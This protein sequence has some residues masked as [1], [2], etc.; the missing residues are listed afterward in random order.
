[1]TDFY[2]DPTLGLSANAGTKLAPKQYISEVTMAA[3][4]RIFL[5][6]GRTHPIS[7]YRFFLSGQSLDAYGEGPLP[8]LQKTA[9]PDA[10][11]Y[12]RN[13]DGVT[14]KNVDLD[15]NGYNGPLLAVANTA[16]SQAVTNFLL[17]NLS[18]SG[19]PN[20]VGLIIAGS[21]GSTVR[22][23]TVRNCTFADNYSHGTICSTDV[24]GVRYEGCISRR[25][26]FGVG[27][28]GFS[29]WAPS[30]S[31][32][33]S[34]IVWFG[35]I[36]EDIVDFDGIEGQGF[37]G[38]DNSS[39]ISAIG[40]IARHCGGYGF[41]FNS[42]SNGLVTGC[43]AHD[44]DGPGFG[45]TGT[46]TGSR[47]YNNTSVGNALSASVSTEISIGGSSVNASIKN[48]IFHGMSR[49]TNGIYVVGGASGTVATHNCAYGVT[50]EASGVTP[51]SS[52]TTDPLL[53]VSYRIP[54][55]S[56]CYEAG[57]YIAGVRDFS[58]RK[59]RRTPDIGAR[60]FLATRSAV[61]PVRS[62]KAVARSAESTPRSSRIINT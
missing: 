57:T 17:D 44:N 53:D 60:Q 42:S 34:N 24:Q 3:N 47:F 35:C 32:A 9:G 39:Y 27:A 46:N 55:T 52:V 49:T 43:I 22:R 26:G 40:C 19:S 25:N 48:N 37:Q 1:M 50:T 4:N 10:W 18:L 6:R 13:A 62:A 16:G 20:S 11:I 51:S 8:I 33:P 41:L 31:P 5:R 23:G 30:A 54:L 14:I 59:L 36:A 21:S 45:T 56:P 28:H 12:I 15:A 2:V 61:S 58:G 7:G 38:D 29:A